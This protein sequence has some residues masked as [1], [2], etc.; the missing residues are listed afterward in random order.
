MILYTLR[1]RCVPLVS[2]ST[3]HHQK[4]C[5]THDL[6]TD[7]YKFVDT[8]FKFLIRGSSFKE[9]YNACEGF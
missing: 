6:D 7:N 1:G 9:E 5:S 8:D 3:N 4:H 2:Y